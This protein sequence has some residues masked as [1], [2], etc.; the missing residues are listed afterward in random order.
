MY[1]EA[2]PKLDHPHEWMGPYKNPET[3]ARQ[4][5]VRTNNGRPDHY[6][7][8][9]KDITSLFNNIS[10]NENKYKSARDKSGNS[11]MYQTV[12]NFE[13]G[14]VMTA[15]CMDWSNETSIPKVFQASIRSISYTDFIRNRAYR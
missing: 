11:E 6:L 15:S 5:N 13:S 12:Y 2:A 10:K 8:F 3:L 1:G 9:N 4:Q 14:D 7:Y